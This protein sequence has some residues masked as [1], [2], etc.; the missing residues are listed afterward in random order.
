MPRSNASPGRTGRPPRTS[1]SDVLAAARLIIERDGWEKL[2]VR[3]LAGE[4]GVSPMTIYHHIEDRGDLLVQLVNDQLARTPTPEFPE[5]PRDRIVAAGVAGRD[6][7][8]AQPWIA[9][10]VT[11][12]GFLSR[13]GGTSIWMVEA[14]VSGALASG[15]TAEQAILVFRNTW[16]FTVGE[17]LVRAN[18]RTRRADAGATASAAIFSHPDPSVS[19]HDAAELPGLAAVGKHWVEV[20]ARDTFAEGLAALVDGLLSQAARQREQ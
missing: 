18:T 13:L 6:A 19:D 14:I 15:C 8:A 12:D 20:S 16:Y 11:T 4:I 9:E 7:L 5:D 3:R 1:R 2:T 17:I 10:V